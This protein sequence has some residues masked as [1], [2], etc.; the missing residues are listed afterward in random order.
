MSLLYKRL[1]QRMVGA[2][3]LIALG[4][5][6]LPMLLSRRDEMPQVIVDAPEMP[7]MP[8]VPDIEVQPVLL[9]EP[10]PEV[11]L[12]AE[13]AGSTPE[14]VLP[15][16]ENAGKRLDDRTLPVSWS[17][18]LASL[19]SRDSAGALVKTLRS[20]GYNAYVRTFDNMNRVLVG[21]VVERAE[22][23]RLRD[24]LNRQHK[25]NGYVVRFEPE[26]Q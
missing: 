26:R 16:D 10:E 4:V 2:L 1:K 14:S 19:S 5:I 7:A 17:V 8:H 18:Q 22:A 20:Q 6:F 25:L 23:E 3:V 12:V 21:P 13:S 9:S 15:A 11:S 24:I